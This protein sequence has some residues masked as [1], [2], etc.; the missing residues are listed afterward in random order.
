MNNCYRILIQGKN[1]SY[2]LFM[3]IQMHIA[4][5]DREDTSNGLILVVSKDDYQKIMDIKTSYKITVLDR[6]G[7]LKIQ[8]L[9]TIKAYIFLF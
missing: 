4:I 1:T 9:L 6:Y 7:F 3:L 5:Y 2:F 8:Y